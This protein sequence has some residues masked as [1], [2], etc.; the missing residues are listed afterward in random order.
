MIIRR[1]HTKSFVTLEN[2][3]VRDKRLTL[4]EHGMLHYLLSLPNEMANH[5]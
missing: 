2:A 5:D 4:D 3:L 1:R